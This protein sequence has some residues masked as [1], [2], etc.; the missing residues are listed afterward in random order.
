MR[1]LIKYFFVGLIAAVAF[2]MI[3][4]NLTRSV[5]KIDVRVFS[6]SA[7]AYGDT[8]V[9]IVGDRNNV[10]LNQAEPGETQYPPLPNRALMSSFLL[11]VITV[12][13]GAV[14]LTIYL[15]SRHPSEP[16]EKSP[17]KGWDSW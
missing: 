1:E 3:A 7:E 9:A 8:A 17:E 4:D 2:S 11:F 5:E 10:T 13:F 16:R 12:L 6:P 15:L 14:L